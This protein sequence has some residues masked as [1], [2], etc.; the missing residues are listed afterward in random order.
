MWNVSSRRSVATLRT[1]IHLLLTNLQAFYTVSMEEKKQPKTTKRSG[2]S[3]H[4]KTE[5]KMPQKAGELRPVSSGV[6][7]A[8]STSV[9]SKPKKK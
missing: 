8:S 6:K 2:G 9:A 3:P 4:D 1:A 7:K 5:G